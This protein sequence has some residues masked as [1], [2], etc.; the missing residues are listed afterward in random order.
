[1]S[2]IFH[3]MNWSVVFLLLV[4]W[5]VGEHAWKVL[6]NCR[7]RGRQALSLAAMP[8]MHCIQAQA[9]V[10][11]EG[12]IMEAVLC[13]RSKS[14]T[15]NVY[16]EVSML[17][18]PLVTSFVVANPVG[19]IRQ[20][21]TAAQFGLDWNKLPP[22]LSLSQLSYFLPVIYLADVN[23]DLGTLG[24]ALHQLAHQHMRDVFPSLRVLRDKPLFLGGCQ[25]RG[26]SF[27]MVHRIAGFPENRAWKG[28]PGSREF[29][30]YFSPDVGMANE[31]CL[32]N[33]AQPQDFK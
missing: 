30:L 28:L 27:S 32:T 9:R 10:M 1:M 15:S 12:K 6:N 29:K 17:D 5:I 8:S 18:S 16:P 26:A 14:P 24:L 19:F 31:L 22:T 2:I 23:S 33:H 4:S 21:A 13:N 11:T 25:Q 7:V 20:P 3:K